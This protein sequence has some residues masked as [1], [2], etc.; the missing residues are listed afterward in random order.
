MKCYLRQEQT[1]DRKEHKFLLS[2]T[3]E[4]IS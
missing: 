1:K 2:Q 3:K 4:L